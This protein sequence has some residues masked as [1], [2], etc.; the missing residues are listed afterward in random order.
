M[1]K[2]LAGL[3]IV[4]VSIALLRTGLKRDQDPPEIH[5][6]VPV[7]TRPFS[8]PLNNPSTTK[9]AAATHMEDEDIVVGVIT[10]HGGRAYPW[11]VLVSY[12][13]VNDSYGRLPVLVT[14]CEVCSGAS[15]FIATVEELEDDTTLTFKVCGFAKGTYEICDHQTLSTWHP[16]RGV[17]GGGR[18]SGLKLER[19]ST[20]VATWKDWKSN[21][22][23]SEVVVASR[24]LLLREHGTDERTAF[25]H[26]YIPEYFFPT[27]NTNDLRLPLNAPVVG[28]PPQHG[29]GE[30][31]I[32]L[33][34]INLS[35]EPKIFELDGGQILVIPR[36]LRSALVFWLN[37]LTIEGWS[38]DESSQHIRNGEL[39]WS[40]VGEPL[41]KQEPLERAD[42]YIAEW[43]EWVSSYPESPLFGHKPDETNP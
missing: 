29:Q 30:I 39:R 24:E 37:G 41:S 26:P 33:R 5:L 1:P 17:A 3:I 38:F 23:D 12:H 7:N 36:Q 10:P 20:Q 8:L 35:P 32:P 31:A 34:D 2:F 25:G 21:F 11:W 18:L 22:P 9:V 43:Y 42:F 14:L 28:M 13:V 27:S 40:L 4:A 16:F 15:A 19:L 6:P